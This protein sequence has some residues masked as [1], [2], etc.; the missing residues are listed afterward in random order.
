[1]RY[2]INED[3]QVTADFRNFS[4]KQ[5]MGGDFA[6]NEIDVSGAAFTF[7]FRMTF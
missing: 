2:R 4:G 3:F 7:G 6:P 1:L 5:K